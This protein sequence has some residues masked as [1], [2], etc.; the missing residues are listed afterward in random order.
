[1][2]QPKGDSDGWHQKILIVFSPLKIG[3]DMLECLHQ[4]DR[5]KLIALSVP[6]FMEPP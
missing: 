4:R 5:I 6:T 2:T 1:M 3:V